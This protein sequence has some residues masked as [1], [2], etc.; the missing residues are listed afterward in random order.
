MGSKEDKWFGALFQMGIETVWQKGEGKIS[1]PI[2]GLYKL[3]NP[4]ALRRDFIFKNH[5]ELV[6]D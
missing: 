2:Q 6:E 5:C 3:L 1:A 4:V